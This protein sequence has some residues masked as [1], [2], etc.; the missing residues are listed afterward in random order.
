MCFLLHG[1]GMLSLVCES[2]GYRQ[3]WY[4]QTIVT[5]TKVA[6][7]ILKYVC[8]IIMYT[9]IGTLRPL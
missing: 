3:F 8:Y 7:V 2:A 4:T 9:Q 1:F 5:N 6:S